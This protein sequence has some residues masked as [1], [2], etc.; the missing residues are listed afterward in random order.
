MGTINLG[1]V[2]GDTGAPGQ[3][4]AN[5]QNGADGASVWIKYNSQPQD[6]GAVDVWQSGMSYLGVQTKAGAVKPTTGYVWSLFT[7]ANISNNLTTTAAGS[8]LDATQG[9]ALADMFKLKYAR[10]KVPLYLPT[11]AAGM[12]F[13][14]I[15]TY[16]DGT[17]NG[18]TPFNSPMSYGYAPAGQNTFITSFIT[19][20]VMLGENPTAQ[21]NALPIFLQPSKVSEF[22]DFCWAAASSGLSSLIQTV[23]TGNGVG[24]N[25]QVQNFVAKS[26]GEAVYMRGT[27]SDAEGA[28]LNAYAHIVNGE[29]KVEVG[30]LI[31]V[32]SFNSQSKELTLF[33]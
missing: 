17:N 16:V 31:A 13:D 30:Q 8:A 33:V 26:V 4:G 25:V 20:L 6:N 2:K 10:G 5:G 28:L 15:C 14:I 18:Y 27:I 9:K 29:V 7:A 3:N 12:S 1:K 11:G 22:K 32:S 23:S 19:M 24:V 21:G